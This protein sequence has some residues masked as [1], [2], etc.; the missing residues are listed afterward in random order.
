M[1]GTLFRLLLVGGFTI[2]CGYV[3]EADPQKGTFVSLLG[4]TKPVWPQIQAFLD[5]AVLDHA[6]FTWLGVLPIHRSLR[7]LAED[8]KIHLKGTSRFG[9]RPDWTLR[10]YCIS[11]D[12]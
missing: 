10:G 5:C 2:I 6:T 3:S 11:S 1:F 12:P 4:F 7:I 9:T 8:G